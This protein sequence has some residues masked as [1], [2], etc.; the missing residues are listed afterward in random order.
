MSSILILGRDELKLVNYDPSSTVEQFRDQYFSTFEE[1][2]TEGDPVQPRGHFKWNDTPLKFELLMGNYP[3]GDEDILVFCEDPTNRLDIQLTVRGKARF[4]KFYF[5]DTTIVNDVK[6][7]LTRKAL[8]DDL[9]PE[10]LVL[11]TKEG[12]ELS[13]GELHVREYGLSHMS[14][15]R[16]KIMPEVV[17]CSLS[18]DLM[19]V[20]FNQQPLS[21]Y[22]NGLPIENLE[23]IVTIREFEWVEEASKWVS[24]TCCEEQTQV[25]PIAIEMASTRC[26]STEFAITVKLSALKFDTSYCLTIHSDN[27]KYAI[28][29]DTV[30][31]SFGTRKPWGNVHVTWA[32]AQL[33]WSESPLPDQIPIVH[34]LYHLLMKKA[35]SLGSLTDYEPLLRRVRGFRVVYE[36]FGEA[37]T[38]NYD[39]REERQEELQYSHYLEGHDLHVEVVEDPL[40]PTVEVLVVAAATV[41]EDEVDGLRTPPRKSPSPIAVEQH[42]ESNNFEMAATVAVVTEDVEMVAAAEALFPDRPPLTPRQ[43]ESNDGLVRTDDDGDAVTRTATASTVAL[44]DHPE[45]QPDTLSVEDDVATETIPAEDP[46]TK[47]AVGKALALLDSNV[48]TDA[49]YHCVGDIAND[50]DV[51]FGHG[52]VCQGQEVVDGEAMATIPLECAVVT[53]TTPVTDQSATPLQQPASATDIQTVWAEPNTDNVDATA[54]AATV[55]ADDA[56]NDDDD[57]EVRSVHGDDV[58]SPA[59]QPSDGTES[60]V[61]YMEDGFLVLMTVDPMDESIL[62]ADEN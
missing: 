6:K 18:H 40:E 59:R 7:D 25:E 31:V 35:M 10:R 33:N 2:S 44:K 17:P 16:A 27:P 58:I 53:A 30:R 12:I 42:Y 61:E 41:V 49:A 3:F 46:A 26:F 55:T 45:E 52:K 15:V 29:S 9:P 36:T 24:I 38:V 57:D 56:D 28:G 50:E 60:L 54:A 13:V 62:V 14:L 21:S 37:I 47:A 34:S 43:T 23:V 5:D 11:F 39:L 48:S 51:I 4:Y 1:Y 8:L 20:R 22:K 19:T 32:N